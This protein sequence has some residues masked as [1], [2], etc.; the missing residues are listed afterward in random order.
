[1]K[2]EIY[3][4]KSGFFI[5][6]RKFMFLSFKIT[7]LEFTSHEACVYWI[8]NKYIPQKYK[9]VSSRYYRLSQTYIFEPEYRSA[10]D[11]DFN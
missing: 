10:I 5:P 8:A 1:M 3:C 9:S 2:I 7:K 11:R 4:K 6:K